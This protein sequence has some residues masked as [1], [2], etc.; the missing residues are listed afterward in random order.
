M[1]D[2]MPWIE[3]AFFGLLTPSLLTMVL[4]VFVTTQLTLMCVTVY[5]HRHSAHRSLE[6]HPASST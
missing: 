3:P 1:I 2:I 5:L 6:L 4:V